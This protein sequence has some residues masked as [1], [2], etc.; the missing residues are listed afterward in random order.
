MRIDTAS[1]THPSQCFATFS[2]ISRRSL[3][4]LNMHLRTYGVQWIRFSGMVG[5]GN[6]SN[7][8]SYRGAVL[9][10]SLADLGRQ[11]RMGSVHKRWPEPAPQD[12]DAQLN[13]QLKAQKPEGLASVLR[14]KRT[15]GLLR[16]NNC[17][18]E[19]CRLHALF[20]CSCIIG[21]VNRRV[22]LS[23]FATS[24]ML[25]RPDYMRQHAC[26][27]HPNPRAM[28]HELQASDHYHMA[29]SSEAELRAA[30]ERVNQIN[31]KSRL[32]RD[33][34]IACVLA[35]YITDEPAQQRL[36]RNLEA[37]TF[38][39]HMHETA[40]LR[41]M[42]MQSENALGH[43]AGDSRH[44]EKMRNALVKSVCF[45]FFAGS[46]TLGHACIP[47]PAHVRSHS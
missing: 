2:A 8:L 45:D 27:V 34:L 15:T 35:D 17:G 42:L 32:F 6:S 19:A 21:G 9:D 16:Q 7:R 14:R 28:R 38:T 1:P 36:I 43:T 18:C 25:C 22:P 44:V 46:T 26:L 3:R 47:V 39:E 12:V 5:T 30:V 29:P 23:D 20:G 11:H 24:N 31:P 4:S 41:W 33:T 10:S 37:Q 40:T 13:A